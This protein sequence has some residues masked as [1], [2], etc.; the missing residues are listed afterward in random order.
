MRKEYEDDDHPKELF[1][2]LAAADARSLSLGDQRPLD[3]GC[4]GG[5]MRMPPRPRRCRRLA[6]RAPPGWVRLRVRL[7]SQRT[8]MRTVT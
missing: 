7:R 1:E 8:G 4:R 3:E 5:D 2:R 6:I